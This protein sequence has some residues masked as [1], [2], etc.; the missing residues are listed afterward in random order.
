MR[1]SI[2]ALPPSGLR[3]GPTIGLPAAG[4]SRGGEIGYDAN[5]M[6]DS[7]ITFSRFK[8]FLADLA[9][10]VALAQDFQRLVSWSPTSLPSE[11]SHAEHEPGDHESP[12]HE[13]QEH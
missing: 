8:L 1:R 7:E 9:S 13:H 10:R 12:E 2:M 6:S 5:R 4:R 11:P 3:S